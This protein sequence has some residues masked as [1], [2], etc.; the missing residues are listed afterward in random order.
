MSSRGPSDDDVSPTAV[1][2]RSLVT[3][4][5]VSDDFIE[6]LGS[7]SVVRLIA[8]GSVGR[9]FECIDHQSPPPDQ[10][11]HVAI[12]LLSEAFTGADVLD[13]LRR[14]TIL[15]G[16]VHSHCVGRVFG[17][18]EH[19]GAPFII[20]ELLR[21][22]NL[23][24]MLDRE[25]KLTP[26]V[27]LR[28][29]RDAARG[30]NAALEVGVTHGD[31][32]P[33]NLYLFEGRVKLVDFGLGG[34]IRPSQPDA[35]A[36]AHT[37]YT[38]L[39]GRT[40]VETFD[41]HVDETHLPNPGAASIRAL[42]ASMLDRGDPPSWEHLVH[43][44]ED[45]IAG[46]P[47]TLAVTPKPPKPMPPKETPHPVDV[48]FPPPLVSA[49]GPA[50][51]AGDPDSLQSPFGAAQS[52]PSTSPFVGVP[53]GIMGS[54]KQMSVTEIAQTLELGRKTARV[55]LTPLSGP[56]GDFACRAGRVVHARCGDLVGEEAFF[57]LAIHTDGYFRIHY[58]EDSVEEA[59]INAPTQFLLLETMRRIDE[60]QT[61]Q[62][63][64][65]AKTN[66][67]TSTN[68]SANTSAPAP[69]PPPSFSFPPSSP[70][71]AA[72][73]SFTPPSPAQPSPPSPFSSSFSPV[74]EPS[75]PVPSPF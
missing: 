40:L 31:V 45:A 21:G 24:T 66:T 17:I 65:P 36:L 35:V 57:A 74:S 52:N 51:P 53:S 58:G 9:V 68:K 12:K 33:A 42:L 37:L 69:A 18:G 38:L 55:E 72:L 28:A 70:A 62:A 50:E 67:A 56:S 11:R 22:E 13:R 26:R 2:R 63:A 16:G 5:L 47:L 43:Q 29:V 46:R 64:P 6:M 48:P 15:L 7:F 25:G 44:L 34:H 23:Q 32:R 54:L 10:G 60:R 19:D 41:N 71:P 1:R 39:T 4:E 75:Q 59:N 3:G 20:E 14:Q 30:L 73:P 61:A 27:A 8:K 49:S